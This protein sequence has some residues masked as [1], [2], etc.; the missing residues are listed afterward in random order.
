MIIKCKNCDTKFRVNGSDVGKYGRMLCCSLC[1]Y[2]WL[3]IPNK[4]T[5]ELEEN[6][7]P[8]VAQISNKNIKKNIPAIIYSFIIFIT[9]TLFLY[10]EREFLI[11]QHTAFEAIYK[12]FDYHNAAD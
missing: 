12:L 7:K 10:V 1:E 11:D 3:Y 5:T 8:A 6:S 4:E 9:L 2:E